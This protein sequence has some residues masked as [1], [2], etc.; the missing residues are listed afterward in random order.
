MSPFMI[1]SL[2]H[3]Q[4]VNNSLTLSKEIIGQKD[5]TQVVFWITLNNERGGV[6][7]VSAKFYSLG[8][9]QPLSSYNIISDVQ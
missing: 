1:Q 5:L 9:V 3:S 4:S 8:S 7:Y 6:A 2:R